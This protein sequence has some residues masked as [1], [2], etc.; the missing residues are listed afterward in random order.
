MKFLELQSEFKDLPI[1]S[2]NDIKN[3]EPNFHR[4]RLNEWQDKGFIKKIIR[5]YYLFSDTPV[6]E[7]ILFKISNQIYYP[8]YISL[9]SAL[10][11]YNLIP[12]TV[13]GITAISTRKTY[14]FKTDLG[15]FSFRSITPKL[16]FGYDLIKNKKYHTKIASIEKTILD[17]FYFNSHLQSI[18]DFSSLR[19]NR[20]AMTE[21]VNE[22]KLFEYLKEINQKRLNERINNFW[23]YIKDVKHRTD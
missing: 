19:I 16:F 15:N 11:Y 2:L 23:R 22:N 12:E 7:E 18:N 21:Q 20:E 1:F 5:G 4:R 3:I 8:S 10:S 14:Q 17:Y 6:D 13:Y 9:E